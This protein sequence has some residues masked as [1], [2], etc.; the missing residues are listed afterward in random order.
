MNEAAANVLLSSQLSSDA[1]PVQS[2]RRISAFVATCV[3]IGVVVAVI[4]FWWLSRADLQSH[5]KARQRLRP[6]RSHVHLFLRHALRSVRVCFQEWERT[7]HDIIR[8]GAQI[9]PRKPIKS[10]S[11]WQ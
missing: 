7:V 2:G 11:T 9:F 10:S 5:Q 1:V 4:T 6:L 3:E 8:R